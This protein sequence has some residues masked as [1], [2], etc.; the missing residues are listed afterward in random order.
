MRTTALVLTLALVV[1]LG[2]SFPAVAG[3]D[4]HVPS[5]SRDARGPQ[6][7]ADHDPLGGPPT[8]RFYVLGQPTI[9][10]FG[11]TMLVVAAALGAY[12]LLLVRRAPVRR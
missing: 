8:P 12:T 11:V 10:V 9:F 6:P 3:A 1:A 7:T 5:I 2:T 4:S